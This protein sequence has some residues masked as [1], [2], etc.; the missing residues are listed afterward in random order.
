MVQLAPAFSVPAQVPPVR[1]KTFGVVG[2]EVVTTLTVIPVTVAAVLLLR[3]TVCAGLVELTG[4]LPNDTDVG[5]TLTVPA[6][7]TNSTAPASTLLL[8]FLGLPKKS[9]AGARL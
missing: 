5:E 8:V 4:T 9:V 6:A 2:V 3:V 7:A 1:E